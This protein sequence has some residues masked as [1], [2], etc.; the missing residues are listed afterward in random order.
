LNGAFVAIAVAALCAGVSGNSNAQPAPAAT[1]RPVPPPP[2]LGEGAPAPLATAVSGAAAT[3]A[4]ARGR[5]GEEAPY[6]GA[7]NLSVTLALV[8]AGGGPATFSAPQFIAALAGDKTQA[9]VASLR[10]RFGPDAVKSFL[11]VFTY[12]VRMGVRYLSGAGLALPQQP[13]PADGKALAASL[14]KLGT[15]PDGKFDVE[16][17]LDGLF[18][19]DIHVRVM[20][21]VDAEYGK[22]A[23]ANFHAALGRAILDLAPAGGP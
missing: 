16:Y 5:F 15:T 14:Y 9:E 17:M 20:D 7:P 21:D 12:A 22:A 18:T 8:S 13:P 23:D 19:H 1:T 4:P 10:D 11:N 6:L 3:A 2:P